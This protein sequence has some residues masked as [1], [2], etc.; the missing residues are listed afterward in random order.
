LGTIPSYTPLA[1]QSSHKIHA[2]Q[3]VPRASEMVLCHLFCAAWHATLIWGGVD[4]TW[5]GSKGW[6]HSWGG[7][8][9]V[10]QGINGGQLVMQWLQGWQCYWCVDGIACIVSNW[11]SSKWNAGLTSWISCFSGLPSCSEEPQMHPSMHHFD[12]W[13]MNS[14]VHVLLSCQQ[15]FFML[16][17]CLRC[18][19][20]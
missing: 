14:L 9:L 15:V 18:R 16:L 12:L 4:C 20:S 7:L 5:V 19:D 10:G 8:V 6:S 11:K 13:C 2:H 17:H 3:M 1:L